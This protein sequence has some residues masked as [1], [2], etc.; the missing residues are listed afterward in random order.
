MSDISHSLTAFDLEKEEYSVE[1]EV[2]EI[3][4]KPLVDILVAIMLINEI[5][6]FL[7][8]E[9]LFFVNHK[10]LLIVKLRMVESIF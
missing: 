1:N 10:M 6:L 2:R 9:L 3:L 5:F 8:N 7:R 4:R